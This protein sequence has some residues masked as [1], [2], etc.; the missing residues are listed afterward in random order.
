MSS[1]CAVSCFAGEA[2]ALAVLRKELPASDEIGYTGP[3]ALPLHVRRGPRSR[4]PVPPLT[5]TFSRREP[6]DNVLLVPTRGTTPDRVARPPMSIPR[7]LGDELDP[8][9]LRALQH[10]VSAPA[11]ALRP[12]CTALKKNERGF[13]GT[14][15]RWVGC[16]PLRASKNGLPHT[17]VLTPTARRAQRPAAVSIERV[18]RLE[19]TVRSGGRRG[20]RGRA[21]RPVQSRGAGTATRRGG[22]ADDS[23]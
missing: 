13:A 5:L 1:T 7:L 15:G 9:V 6:P 21:S 4:W 11:L 3:S 12:A 22:E 16:A 18:S 10:S 17:P 23:P 2:A 19:H 20:G 14:R 8:R